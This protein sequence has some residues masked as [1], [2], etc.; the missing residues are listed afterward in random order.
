M[1]KTLQL[2]HGQ[3]LRKL[4]IENR[5]VWKG[6]KRKPVVVEHTIA[7][8]E[9]IV[10]AWLLDYS[11]GVCLTRTRKGW[12]A[13]TTPWCVKSVLPSGPCSH[14]EAMDALRHVFWKGRKN[15]KRII[16][17]WHRANDN[18]PRNMSVEDQIKFDRN[19]E[20]SR[21]KEMATAR[22]KKKSKVAKVAK[23]KVAAKKTG[24]K[25]A[26]GTGRGKVGKTTGLNVTKAWAHI[27][28]KNAKAKRSARMTD[29]EISKWMRKE[30]PPGCAYFD[31]PAMSRNHYNQG[32]LT[33]GDVPKVKSVPFD[34]D[35][36]AMA[37]R[38]RSAS[39]KPTATKKKVGKKKV[40]KKAVTKK[41][42]SKRTR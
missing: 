11:L 32:K 39:K 27:F 22:K 20:K 9:P 26:P 40:A 12:R 25:R 38:Q 1:R 30:F 3:R 33:D 10:T 29:A 4:L 31:H 16:A 6:R 42:K 17:R 24:T 28:A 15:K 41:K 36:N 34:G 19:Q 23:K 14:K 8:S 13:S 21:S 5:A 35:G 37:V 7:C 18:R 2:I